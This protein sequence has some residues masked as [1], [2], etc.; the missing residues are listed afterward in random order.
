[1]NKLYRVLGKRGRITI[2][3]EIRQRVGFAYNDVLSFSESPDGQTVT[4]KREKICDNCKGAQPATGKDEVTLLDF[5]NELSDEQQR[6][7]L[8]HLSVKLA[9]KQGGGAH[10]R[11]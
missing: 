5:L 10:G 8:L 2:P 9:E 6:A 1:M 11:A 7:A 3:F 4:V